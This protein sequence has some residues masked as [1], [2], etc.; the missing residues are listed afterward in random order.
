[1]RK[2]IEIPGVVGRAFQAVRGWRALVVLAVLTIALASV[3]VSTTNVSATHGD[4]EMWP[5]WY[6]GGE[7]SVLMYPIGH[8]KSNPKFP[9]TDCFGAWPDNTKGQSAVEYP[10]FYIL[11]GIGGATQMH[12]PDGSSMH[13]MVATAAPGDTNYSPKV[14]LIV[15]LEG[16][17]YAG[18]TFTSEQAVLD[19]IDDL[20]LDCDAVGSVGVRL[21]PVVLGP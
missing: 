3:A 15:C 18:G 12:C 8:K 6:D 7:V 20:K 5:T 13:D 4:V 2:E 17:S 11:W 1:M 9:S 10:A 14:E 19:A 16:P 21:S